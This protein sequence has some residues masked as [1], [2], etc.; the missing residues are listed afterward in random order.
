MLSLDLSP[1]TQ[2]FII[3]VFIHYFKNG[4]KEKNPEKQ[5][6]LQIQLIK[7]KGIDIILYVLSVSL[8]DVKRKILKLFYYLVFHNFKEV[9]PL[10]EMNLTSIFQIIK[11]YIIPNNLQMDFCGKVSLSQS[12]LVLGDHT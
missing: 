8:I 11:Q 12:T 6:E 10:L 3:K 4:K 1:C 2:I 5:R 9:E 7:N